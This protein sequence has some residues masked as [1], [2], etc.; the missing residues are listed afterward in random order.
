MGGKRARIGGTGGV[1]ELRADGGGDGVE[2]V[3]GGLV[4]NLFWE[5]EREGVE[6][7]PR[8]LDVSGD[9]AHAGVTIGEKVRDATEQRPRGASVG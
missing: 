2:V 5:G 3:S 6:S 7:G 8:A 1:E 4:V 9:D